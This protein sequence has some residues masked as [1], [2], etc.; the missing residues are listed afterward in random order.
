VKLT[1]PIK[2]RIGTFFS[3]IG[4]V[5]AA[6]TGVVPSFAAEVDPETL[7]FYNKCHGT[8]FKPQSVMDI[9]PFSIEADLFH[10]SPVCKNFSVAGS[11]EPDATDVM[12]ANSISRMITSRRFKIVTVENVPQYMHSVQYTIITKALTE[13]GYKWQWYIGDAADFG[14]PQHR[15]RLLIRASLDQDIVFKVPETKPRGDWYAAIKDLVEYAPH[16]PLPEWERKRLGNLDP[17]VPVITMGGSV[18]RNTALFAVAGNPAPTIKAGNEAARI[19]INGYARR[20]TP[21]MLA[22]LMSYPNSLPVPSSTR[23]ARRMLGNGVQGEFT[24]SL[25][26]P[27]IGEP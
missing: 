25:I 9:D 4:T 20:V 3:G 21:R 6:L 24:R 12:Y 27:L 7:D 18:N 1:A 8:S 13:S 22:R 16:S 11:R 14:A 19:I 2:K 17:S 15:Q 5:E 10:A 26:Q 23:A